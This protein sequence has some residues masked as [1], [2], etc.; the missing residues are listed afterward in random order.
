M[1]SSCQGL[2]CRLPRRR[3]HVCPDR[4][5]SQYCLVLINRDLSMQN[6]NCDIAGHG[7]TLSTKKVSPWK[8]IFPASP[9]VEQG[10]GPSSY[11][12]G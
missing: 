11:P 6:R 1:L 5:S 10:K 3:I 2:P 8:C 7:S 4:D 9:E 12:A